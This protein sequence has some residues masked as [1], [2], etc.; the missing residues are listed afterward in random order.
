MTALIWGARQPLPNYW[1]LPPAGGPPK[2]EKSEWEEAEWG[3]WH[4]YTWF[5]VRRSDRTPPAWVLLGTTDAFW[6]QDDAGSFLGPRAWP[7]FGPRPQIICRRRFESRFELPGGDALRTEWKTI[8]VDDTTHDQ[9]CY[10]CSSYHDLLLWT[11]DILFIFW[12]T[13]K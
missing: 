2:W 3:R 10:R 1:E 7:R 8:K 9:T 11:L 4:F 13:C 6:D 5:G 12:S